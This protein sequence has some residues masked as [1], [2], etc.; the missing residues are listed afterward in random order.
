MQSKIHPF[1]FASKHSAWLSTNRCS[2]IVRVS[3]VAFLGC[4]MFAAME[5]PATAND[6]E[7]I[8]LKSGKVLEG[9]ISTSRHGT[10]IDF[11]KGDYILVPST[12][13]EKSFENMRDLVKYKAAVTPLSIREQSR[14]LSWLVEYEEFEMA[15]LQLVECQKAEVAIDVADWKKQIAKARSSKSK[16]KFATAKVA[17]SNSALA[18]PTARSLVKT[19]SWRD[20]SKASFTKNVQQHLVMGCG[21]S[22]CHDPTSATKLKLYSTFAKPIDET[23]TA[24][25]FSSAS[26]FLQNAEQARLLH[27]MVMTAHGR[28]TSP[29]YPKPSKPY[30]AIVTWI[31]ATRNAMPRPIAHQSPRGTAVSQPQ[32]QTQASNNGPKSLPVLT[33]NS[34][35]NSNQNRPRPNSVK[36]SSPAIPAPFQ[37]TD[38]FGSLSDSRF[39]DLDAMFDEFQPKD[40]FDPEI[41]NRMQN[42]KFSQSLESSTVPNEMKQPT[43]QAPSRLIS[44]DSSKS[45]NR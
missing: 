33:P 40:E 35:T 8:L 2:R 16:V 45:K 28:L 5:R 38:S 11:P 12:R 31:N 19:E 1:S 25:N 15:E 18:E 20:L 44:P 24:K 26:Q 14:L 13:F 10:R 42:E 7:Y 29:V 6:G 21:L 4:A 30:L 9:S 43:T 39:S 34:Q 17:E 23:Q 41:F 32:V 3:L 27:E 22:G 37:G 36:S